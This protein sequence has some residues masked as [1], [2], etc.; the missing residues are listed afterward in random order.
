MR[1]ARVSICL[2]ESDPPLRQ[3]RL[4]RKDSSLFTQANHIGSASLVGELERER[5][6]T[7]G[8]VVSPNVSNKSANQLALG[9]ERS[10]RRRRRSVVLHVEAQY[11]TRM[12]IA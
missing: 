10:M 6:M 12:P 8:L 7:E 3:L 1:E 5:Q 2:V 4:E 9:L 11:I